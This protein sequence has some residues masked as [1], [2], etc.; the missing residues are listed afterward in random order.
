MVMIINSL[1]ATKSSKAPR[2]LVEPVLLATYPSKWS[3]M[4]AITNNMRAIQ[5][6]GLDSGEA[7]IRTGNINNILDKVR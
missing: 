1:S 5:L 3:V 2:E 6:F 7:N 4:P